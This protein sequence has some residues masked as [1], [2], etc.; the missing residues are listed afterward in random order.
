[1]SGYTAST[2]ITEVDF[3]QVKR[4]LIDFMSDQDTWKDYNF[5]ASG[6]DTI[7]S[8]LA[9]AIHYS[10]YYGNMGSAEVFLDSAQLRASIVSKAKA[11]SYTPKSVVAAKA[12]VDLTFTENEGQ[13]LPM[14]L[15]L[16]KGTILDGFSSAEALNQS[17]YPFVITKTMT[18]TA[19]V[20]SRYV[21][22]EVTLVQG[23][24]KSFDFVVDRR[25]LDQRFV[26][27]HDKIDMS[28]LEV[29]IQEGNDDTKLYRYQPARDILKL[30]SDSRVYYTQEFS[31]G[32]FE[33]FFGDGI[34]GRRVEHGR[35]IRVVYMETEGEE[36]NDLDSFKLVRRP[37]TNASADILEAD[38]A[39]RLI[40]A[41]TGGTAKETNE[42]IKFA[43]PRHFVTRSRALST[44]DWK[45]IVMDEFSDI[46]S[47]RVWGGEDGVFPN[48]QPGWV[49]LSLN[50]KSGSA[51]TRTRK[52]EILDKLRKDSRVLGVIPVIVD[53]EFIYI[54]VNSRV[55][56]D[57]NSGILGSEEVT[58]A[59]RDKILSYSDNELEQFDGVYEVSR[60]SA[61]I[62]GISGTISSNITNSDVQIRLPVSIGRNVSYEFIFQ[63]ELKPGTIITNFCTVDNQLVNFTDDGSGNIRMLT[64]ANK[65]VSN[66]IGQVDYANGRVLIGPIYV[67]NADR[68]TQLR[69]NAVTASPNIETRMNKILTIDPGRIFVRPEV[70]K[71]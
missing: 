2:R 28:Y 42:S 71:K 29:Y 69:L 70:K 3:D 6:L 48:N 5:V 43:A 8:Q 33:I 52:Q 13:T 68:T 23:Q 35:V 54:G 12:I 47:V 53:P 64:G 49:Y 11:L 7:V 37:D 40:Q 62:D 15:I 61:L 20:L 63:N 45:S 22:S 51:L 44:D 4:N 67:Q 50:P 32:R 34:F 21:Y 25:D 46:R 30:T 10:S 14:S 55:I 31:D 9:Y 18:A 38:M 19:D 27:P 26:L 65:V 58:R 1:M 57:T 66:T 60:I 39:F 24:Y 36:G 59:V 16:D 17:T 41:S 56:L